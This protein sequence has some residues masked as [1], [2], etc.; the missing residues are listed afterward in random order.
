[1]YSPHAVAVKLV[2]EGST[3]AHKRIQFILRMVTVK[4]TL[5]YAVGIASPI[6][7]RDEEGPKK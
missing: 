2:F 5:V 4:P 3:D 6:A 1:M 7:M